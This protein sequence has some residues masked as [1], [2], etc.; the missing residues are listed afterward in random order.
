MKKKIA[1]GLLALT[2]FGLCAAPSA[3]KVFAKGEEGTI[4]TGVF[5]DGLDASG[6]TVDEAYEEYEKYVEALEEGTLKLKTVNG[7]CEVPLSDLGITVSLD[8]AVE[9]AYNYGRKGNILK[10]YKE[11]NTIKTENVT[12][13][14]DKTI[15][16]DLLSEALDESSKDI[17]LEAKNAKFYR[18]N[19]EF[20]CD[21][22]TVGIKLNKE[23]TI[24]AIKD[25]LCDEWSGGD[26]E[27]DAVVEETQP[28]YTQ[29]DFQKI[30]DVIGECST[31]YNGPAARDNNLATG[32]SKVD[33]T[34]LYPGQEFN[35]YDTV[36]P[37]TAENGYKEA[38]QYSD[39]ELIQGFGG[40]ICQV[41]TT[42]YVAVLRAELQVTARS[43]HSMAVS[44]VKQSMD[45]AIAGTYKNFKFVN[46]TEYPIYIE[47]YAKGGKLQFTI[48]G[49]ETRPS[50]RKIEFE[51]K[52]ITTVEPPEDVETV[53]N[54]KPAGYREKV[55]NAHTGYY[56]ELWK[57]VYV[58]GEKTD[59]IKINSSNYNATPNKYI[60]GPE[61]ASTEA[62]TAAPTPSPTPTTE[63]TTAATTAATTEATTVAP[64]PTEGQ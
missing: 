63:A 48:Y 16:E 13:I 53:D 36:S 58:D 56:A 12:L 10:R 39:G 25:A 44:Y 29:A 31:S 24:K 41:T 18:K 6:L 57:N 3:G 45:A 11:I 55:S 30:N 60:I 19:G 26:L 37:F 52:V 27:V 1:I 28:E 42:L 34:V 43:S 21:P 4:Y 17:E 64:P 8:D 2:I 14:P 23:D 5:I 33:G 50:N 9:E 22:E 40:G 54:T 51:S 35:M 49:C 7:E 32:A 59:S 47:G 62:T 15:D 61:E 38:G 46:N 20:F